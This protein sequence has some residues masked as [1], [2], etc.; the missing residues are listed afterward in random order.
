[1]TNILSVTALASR[2]PDAEIASKTA[3]IL[4]EAQGLVYL[5]GLPNVSAI[6]VA[7]D[8]RHL[9]SGDFEKRAYVPSISSFTE[10]FRTPA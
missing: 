8:G 6:L 7:E 2:L 1:V 9:V 5:T 3:L 4:G 10:R